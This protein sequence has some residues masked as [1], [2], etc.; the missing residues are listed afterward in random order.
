MIPDLAPNT[1]TRPY[2]GL[3]VQET[4]VPLTAVDL[5]PFLLGRE[6]YRRTE[7][8]VLRN[9]G[10]SA[11]VACARPPPNPCSPPDRRARVLAGPAE[12]GVRTCTG[13]RRRQA[14]RWP[15][16]RLLTFRSGARAYVVHAATSM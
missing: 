7:Y 9:D 1:T 11:L 8:L 6:V 4:D 14:R 13:D 12:V 15:A 3:S 2:R 5:V 16:R 10:Q